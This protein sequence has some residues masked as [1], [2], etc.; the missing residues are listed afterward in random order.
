MSKLPFP[1]DNPRRLKNC[2]KLFRFYRDDI[3]KHKNYSGDKVV[4]K[5]EKFIHEQLQ[6]LFPAFH[7]EVENEI[8]KDKKRSKEKQDEDVAFFKDQM[9]V[10]E[11]ALDSR[12]VKFDKEVRLEAAREAR[13]TVPMNSMLV[14]SSLETR[15]I[16]YGLLTCMFK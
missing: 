7:A 3:R 13:K 14:I 8:R 2:D 10:R 5:R 12:D 9:S 1:I 4:K 15:N 11:M 6:A 16:N